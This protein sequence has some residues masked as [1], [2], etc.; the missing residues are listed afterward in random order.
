MNAVAILAAITEAI[1]VGSVL[2]QTG[3]DAM[4]VAEAIYRAFVKNEEVTQ[5]QLDA[6]VLE[7][8]KLSEELQA[9]LE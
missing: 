6:F 4:P 1:R 2:V 3:R 5:E 7:T 8:E 9:P